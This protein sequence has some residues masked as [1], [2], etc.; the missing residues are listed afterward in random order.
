MSGFNEHLNIKIT[1]KIRGA[2][3]S[4]KAPLSTQMTTLSIG[5]MSRE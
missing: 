1:H 3:K 4:Q 5:I 2:Q